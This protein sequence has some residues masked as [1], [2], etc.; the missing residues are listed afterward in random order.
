MSHTPDPS[1]PPPGSAASSQAVTSSTGYTPGAVLTVMEQIDSRPLTGHQK[2][3]ISLVIVGNIAEFFD[4]F[5]IGFV[6]S[7]LT[8][9]WNLTGL[10]A[11]IILACSGLGTVIGSIV[12]GWLADKIGRRSSF[13]GC[14]LIFSLFTLVSIFTPER[15]WLILAV[16]RVFVGIGVG[17]LNITSIPYAQEFVPAKQRGLL[18]GLASV[19][20]PLGL[21]LG[22]LAQKGF[23]DN[24]RALIALGALPILLLF[25]IRLVPESP[26]FLQAK[27]RE[28]E[29]RKSLAWAM[30]LP[31]DQVGALPVLE[32]KSSASMSVIFRD[33][34]KPLLIVTLGSFCFIFGSFT[35]QSWGQTLLS[36]GFGKSAEQVASLFMLVSLADLLGRLGSAWAADKVGRRWTMFIWG[37][38]GAVGCVVIAFAAHNHMSWVVFYV[39]VLVTMAFGDGAFGILNAFGSEQFP[40]EARSTGLGLGYGIGASAKIFGPA[41]MGAMIGGNMLQQQ[42]TLDAVFPAFIFFA[43]LLL[44]GGIIYLFAR[45]TKGTSL[46]SV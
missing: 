17:G 36:E 26:R 35:V 29:A 5:L 11:G 10:E 16:L 2:S 30:E 45:E 18:S 42:V 13:Y 44:A 20:I 34:R 4:M 6:V 14:V 33:Y 39:G 27:G 19:F 8:K 22:S 24:W 28:D 1:A 32:E 46:D 23:H 12:W 37:S 31:V 9:P 40:N 3:I 21:F 43:V 7:L 15:G 25:W 38:L 41:L